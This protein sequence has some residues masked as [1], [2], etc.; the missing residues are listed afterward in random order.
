MAQDSRREIGVVKFGE[1]LAST[2]SRLGLTQLDVAE[3]LIG[4]DEEPRTIAKHQSRL[5]AI[6]RQDNLTEDTFVRVAKAMGC[7]VEVRLV[8]GGRGR[9]YE[10]EQDDDDE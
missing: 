10:L 7:D 6:V 9:V 2:M 8:A 3:E 5:S 1:I 4:H